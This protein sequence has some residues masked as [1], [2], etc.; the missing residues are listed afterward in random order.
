MDLKVHKTIP[1]IKWPHRIVDN[2]FSEKELSWV[3]KAFKYGLQDLQKRHPNFFSNGTLKEYEELKHLIR[4][5]RLVT[6]FSAYVPFWNTERIADVIDD[7]WKEATEI[8]PYQKN[9]SIRR[10]DYFS[11]L[12]LNIYPVGMS[13]SPHMDVDYKAFTGVVYIGEEGDGT[14]LICSPNRVDVTWKNNRGVL[15]MN[16]DKERRVK[17]DRKD[18]LST[19]HN[20]ANK[21]DELRFAVNFNM[22]HPDNVG[23]LL[24]LMHFRDKDL[25]YPTKVMKKYMPKFGPIE[26]NYLPE[27]KVPFGDKEKK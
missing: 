3:N 22:T 23:N 21:T 6:G 15:F 11:F 12:E 16:C 26:V 2:F 5:D 10:K 19:W 7:V 20:Y 9:Q 13:Y 27:N 4:K 18:E 8:Y 24:T 1:D 17:K 25:F 14:T